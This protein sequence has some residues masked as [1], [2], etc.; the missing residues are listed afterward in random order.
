MELYLFYIFQI[1]IDDKE[2]SKNED[3]MSPI[4]I[5]YHIIPKLY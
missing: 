2:S 3:K 1:L 5:C 4:L